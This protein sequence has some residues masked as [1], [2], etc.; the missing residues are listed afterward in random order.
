MGND[1]QARD[2]LQ[3]TFYRAW[4]TAQQGIPPFGAAGDD[5]AGMCR[6]QD[7][8]RSQHRAESKCRQSKGQEKEEKPWYN[9][10][11]CLRKIVLTHMLR[12]KG[13][14]VVS[15]FLMM[16]LLYGGEGWF[17]IFA[18]LLLLPMLDISAPLSGGRSCALC[19]SLR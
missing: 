17:F 1:E 11:E 14:T 10:Y 18:D 8:D 12:R 6:W 9:K 19:C 2:L 4:R 3:D 16:E 13:F 15:H 5:E 7:T